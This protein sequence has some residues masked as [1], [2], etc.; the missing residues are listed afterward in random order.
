M[1]LRLPLYL[2]PQLRL[3]EVQDSGFLA[4]LLTDFFSASPVWREVFVGSML[5]LQ[6][7][8]LTIL[9]FNHRIATEVTLFPGVFYI[10]FSASH[11]YFFESLGVLVANTFLLLA[12]FELFRTFRIPGCADAI[13]N[14]GLCIGLASL[15]SLSYMVFLV[16][17]MVSLSL[18]RAFKLREH[19]MI[20]AGF[21]VVYLLAGVWAFWVEEL[22]GF[23]SAHFGTHFGFLD[24]TR[25][26]WHHDLIGLLYGGILLF[27]ALAVSGSFFLKK[28][29]QTQK[30]ISV[31]YL[32]MLVSVGTLLLQGHTRV[33]HLLVLAVPIG[34]FYS[35][36]FLEMEKRWAEFFFILWIVLALVY[37]ISPLIF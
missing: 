15:F 22:P 4:Q 17:G 24:F 9:I 20:L 18:L 30:Y 29:I 10:L 16:W 11:P 34:A 35:F 33:G 3:A 13:F 36:Q 28:K 7:F 5:V 31:L 32:L 27:F 14:V 37:Q 19:L 23:L 25:G 12:C 2:F 26:V 1:L 8:L 21:A 6:A